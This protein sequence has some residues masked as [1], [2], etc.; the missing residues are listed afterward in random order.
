MAR[1]RVLI[2][3]SPHQASALAEQLLL[4][5]A[6]P[7]LI[8]TIELVEPSSFAALDHALSKMESFDWL[9]FTSANS[10]EAFA[11]RH[12]VPRV[13][14]QKIGAIG[15]ATA[16]ALEA[17]GLRADVVPPQAVAESLAEALLPFA[18]REDGGAARFLLVRAEVGREVLPETLLRRIA[19]WW[20][21]DRSGRYARYLGSAIA[22][23]TLSASPAVL[24]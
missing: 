11:R 1:P 6:E 14:S 16:K 17:V 9:L 8:P 12:G 7:L 4:L 10:V 18:E 21:K 5:G 15:S 23:L 3:R 13:S 24:L 22:G 2:I 19:R 20:R